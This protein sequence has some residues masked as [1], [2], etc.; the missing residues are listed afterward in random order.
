MKVVMIGVDVTDVTHNFSSD[1]WDKLR[2]CGGHTY[3]YQRRDF[4]SGRGSRGGS[5]DRGGR[6]SQGGFR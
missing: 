2:A 6:A 1:E 5:D 4:L 3:E